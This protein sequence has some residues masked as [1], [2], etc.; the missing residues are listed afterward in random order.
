MRVDKPANIV[1]AI[2]EAV[3]VTESGSPFLLEFV[4]KEGHDFSRYNL[5]GL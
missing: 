5:A 2:K 3:K 1:P 4:V